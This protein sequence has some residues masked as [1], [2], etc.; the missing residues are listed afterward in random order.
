M[1]GSAG[2]R[3][4]LPSLPPAR[5]EPSFPLPFCL[6]PRPVPPCD[7]R[8]RCARKAKGPLGRTAT[9]RLQQRPGHQRPCATRAGAVTAASRWAAARGAAALPL[10]SSPALPPL[11]RFPSA[12]VSPADPANNP[13]STHS[14]PPRR[15][16]PCTSLPSRG[17][18]RARAP[19]ALPPG[20]PGKR[21]CSSPSAKFAARPPPRPTAGAP[22]GAARAK[23]AARPLHR[24]ETTRRKRHYQPKT[25]LAADP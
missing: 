15:R 5:P 3:W 1:L 18:R 9:R 22:V 17:R 20:G 14:Q 10:R 8:V 6:P 24:K 16:A 7:A 12:H 4:E 2:G 11:P 25:T 19:P 13:Q 21:A 23:A